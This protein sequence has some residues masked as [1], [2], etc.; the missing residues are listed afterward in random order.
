MCIRDSYISA[1]SFTAMHFTGN[2]LIGVRYGA[3]AEWSIDKDHALDISLR[4][5]RE[6]NLPRMQYRWIVGV[7]YEFK[8][9]P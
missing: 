6:Q 1:E 2:R 5:D 7:A 4:Y 3:G 8:W 9:K